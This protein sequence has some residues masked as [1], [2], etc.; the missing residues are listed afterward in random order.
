MTIAF[1]SPGYRAVEAESA[2]EAARIFAGRQAR[3]DFGRRGYVRTLRLDC[4]TEDRRSHTFEAFIGYNVERDACA[5]RNV[6]I[7]VDQAG[8]D[9]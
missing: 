4:W 3:R 6:W 5:G 2:T 7:Y 1:R 9:P 8:V